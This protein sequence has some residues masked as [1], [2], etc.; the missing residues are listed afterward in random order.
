MLHRHPKWGDWSLVGGHVEQGEE[1]DWLKTASRE[2]EEELAP[3]TLGGD[4]TVEPL[5]V[6]LRWG[7]CPSRSAGGM[8]TEY[9]A[10]YF[11][12]RFLKDPREILDV[13]PESEFRLVPIDEVESDE[14]VGHPV[15]VFLAQPEDIETVAVSPT[16]AAVPRM[17]RTIADPT[18][19]KSAIRKRSGMNQRGFIGVRGMPQSFGGRPWGASA[20]AR[21][22]VSGGG[23]SGVGPRAMLRGLLRSASSL[24]AWSGRHQGIGIGSPRKVMKGGGGFEYVTPRVFVQKTSAA[25]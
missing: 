5:P 7:P 11:V 14:G 8:P 4:F 17:R 15:R 12:L 2:A 6:E 16:E 18:A 21:S 3:L 24:R 23:A 20:A 10:R 25:V 22:G 13:L 19:P 1:D 9:R